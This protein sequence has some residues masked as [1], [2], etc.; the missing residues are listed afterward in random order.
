MMKIS[1]LDSSAAGRYEDGCGI[2][3]IR[4]CSSGKSYIGETHQ[5]RIRNFLHFDF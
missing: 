1:K 4:N 5:F 3:R 2:Y